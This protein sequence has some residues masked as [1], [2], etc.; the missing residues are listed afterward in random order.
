MDAGYES[1]TPERL[2]AEILEILKGT[3]ETREGSYANTLM[4][5]VAYQLYKIYQLMPRIELMAFPDETA[6]EYIDRRCA[7]FGIVRT[8]GTKAHVTIRFTASTTA[9]S[10]AVPAGTAAVTE[11]A[12]RFVTQAEA[13]FSNGVADV[14]AL[15]EDIGRKYNVEAGAIT[16]LSVNVGGLSS[17]T[18]PAPAEGGSDDETD[19]SL[20]E[21]YHE[22]LRRPVSSGN[23]N[24]YIAWARAAPGVGSAAAVPVW[25]GPGTVKVIVAGPE[26]EPV[27]ETVVSACAQHIEQE[28]PIGADVTVVSARAKAVAVTAQVTL[29]HGH[30]AGEVAGQLRESLGKLLAAM[31]FGQDNLLRYSRALALLLDCSGVEEYHAFA[32]NGASANVS[33]LAEE[34]LTV[35]NV[36]VTERGA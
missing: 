36:T 10:P 12:L 1:M 8:K 20:L 5:P 21:R 34:T 4:S 7:D 16:G 6:G 23:V 33:A 35:G 25:N 15:A 14:L 2:K 22:H 11:D 32:L 31:P 30:T 26:K 24:H 28:R 17:V 18:N 29:I 9:A 13:V 27:D 3:M 19:G